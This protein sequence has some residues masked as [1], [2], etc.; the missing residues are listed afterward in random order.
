M[1]IE[2]VSIY[3][4]IFVFYHTQ[5]Y[6]SS[7][8]HGSF[9]MTQTRKNNHIDFIVLELNMPNRWVKPSYDFYHFLDFFLLFHLKSIIQVCCPPKQIHDFPTSVAILV[10]ENLTRAIRTSQVKSRRSIPLEGGWSRNTDL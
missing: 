3:I 8:N 6:T 5:I 4:Y 7:R 9:V 2:S 10:C 1:R